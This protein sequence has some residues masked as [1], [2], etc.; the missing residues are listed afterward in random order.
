MFLAKQMTLVFAYVF[1]LWFQHNIYPD[2]LLL[3]GCLS[4]WMRNKAAPSFLIEHRGT[5]FILGSTELEMYHVSV[6]FCY[7]TVIVIQL[8]VYLWVSS[9]RRRSTWDDTPQIT[10]SSQPRTLPSREPSPRLDIREPAVPRAS[11]WSS[12]TQP[13]LHSSG[14]DDAFSFNVAKIFQFSFVNIAQRLLFVLR[15]W[16][17]SCY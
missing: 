14:Q 5:F 11:S 13:S 8:P 7:V 16:R 17:T 15:I 1:K 3:A 12:S 2:L 9:P 10:L 4:H 6:L